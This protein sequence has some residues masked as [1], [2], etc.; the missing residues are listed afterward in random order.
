MSRSDLDDGNDV[1]V[2]AVPLA[3]L[4]ITHELARRPARPPR[5][6]AENGALRRLARHMSGEG[7]SLL[8]TLVATA[9]EL[10]GA[11]TAG[12][13]ILESDDQGRERFRWVAVA[14]QL[15]PYVGRSMARCLTPAGL[16]ID[17]AAPILLTEPGRRF[18][19]LRAIDPPIAE[20]LLLPLFSNGVPLGTMWL[21]AHDDAHRFDAEDVRV[22]QSLTDFTAAAFLLVRARTEAERARAAAEAANRSKGQFLAVMS[23]ELRTPLNAIRGYAELVDLGV[24]GPVTEGQHEALRRIRKNERHLLGLINDVLSFTRAEAGH[25]QYRCTALP[26]AEVVTDVG[27]LVAPQLAAKQL[28]IDVTAADCSLTVFADPDKARQILVNLFSNAAK[29]TDA[30]GSVTLTC[31]GDERRVRVHVRDT[32]CGIP[33][34]MLGSIFEP[35]MRVD[36]GLTRQT[37]GVGLGL[38]ISRDLA[39]GMGGDLTVESDPGRGATFT[40]T[41]PSHPPDAATDARTSVI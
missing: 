40:L 37:Q 5:L 12:V 1:E 21:A 26:L 9:H 13:S 6:D 19:S 28:V 32:G 25:V 15:G 23:H 11:D 34:D 18:A 27:A 4:L 29:F 17:A 14:G 35:F 38:A 31:D 20:A 10:S 8:E 30:G 39:R 2:D 41:L 16:C 24:Y 22:M 33:A 3:E 7:H 36:G